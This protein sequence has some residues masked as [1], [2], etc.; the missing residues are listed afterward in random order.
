MRG[1]FHWRVYGRFGYATA[2]T[3]HSQV[4]YPL[5]HRQSDHPACLKFVRLTPSAS[6]PLTSRRQSQGY[7]P[8]AGLATAYPPAIHRPLCPKH[9]LSDFV[10]LRGDAFYQLDYDI[11]AIQ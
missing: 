7:V 9:T 8:V 10:L 3:R 4:P 5:P 2:D 1:D 6:L 11:A